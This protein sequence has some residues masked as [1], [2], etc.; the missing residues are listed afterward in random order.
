MPKSQHPCLSHPHPLGMLF[1]SL[2]FQ[3]LTY[4]NS[5]QLSLPSFLVWPSKPQAL[6]TSSGF[7]FLSCHKQPHSILLCLSSSLPFFSHV[8]CCL[9]TSPFPF[10]PLSVFISLT[11]VI[12]SYQ[13]SHSSHP[14]SCSSGPAHLWKVFLLQRLPFPVLKG[15][16]AH[17][18]ID[19]VKTITFL[20]WEVTIL[21][22]LIISL[23]KSHLHFIISPWLEGEFWKGEGS[24]H[25][26]KGIETFRITKTEKIVGLS[27]R[28]LEN[29]EKKSRCF[30][31][32]SIT[33]TQA[34]QIPVHGPN[35][36]CFLYGLCMRNSFYIFKWLI[37]K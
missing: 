22:S 26:S 35:L 4:L 13:P 33:Q 2:R 32:Y 12:S 34:G 14:I 37:K 23:V 25:V 30:K 36:A 8:P 21:L 5:P 19:K 6:L 31:I 17:I 1:P 29:S 3:A 7:N 28:L 10:S 24:Q 11:N 16:R 9:L 18:H 20:P 27:R 15:H